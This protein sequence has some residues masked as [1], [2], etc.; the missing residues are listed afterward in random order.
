MG[1]SGCMML[2]KIGYEFVEAGSGCVGY[3][4][5]A[6]LC[7]LTVSSKEFNG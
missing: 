5:F 3:D 6:L 2:G 1:N 4:S 7:L